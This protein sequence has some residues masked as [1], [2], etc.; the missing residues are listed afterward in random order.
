MR[1]DE[2]K[3]AYIKR[4]IEASPFNNFQ[5]FARLLLI[6]GEIHLTD[7]SHLEKLHFEVNR[8][9]NNIN[10][11]TKL[12]HEYGEVS[13]MDIREVREMMVELDEKVSLKL[14][15]EKRSGRRL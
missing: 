7:Y 11:L 5:N 14:K 9:G 4:K 8:I 2:N 10:Q 6:T 3:W 12:A 15:E 13:P 1:F